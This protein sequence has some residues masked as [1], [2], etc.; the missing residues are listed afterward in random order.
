M[1]T[2]S[3][4]AILDAQDRIRI[5]HSP[6]KRLGL[7]EEVAKV[8]LFLASDDSSFVVGLRLPPMVAGYSIQYK[9]YGRQSGAETMKSLKS[10]AMLTEFALTAV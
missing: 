2:G 4:Q 3:A 9:T 10:L 6:V 7:P 5:S 1:Y 8:V